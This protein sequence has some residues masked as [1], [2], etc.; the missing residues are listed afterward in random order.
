MKKK[1]GTKVVFLKTTQVSPCSFLLLSILNL[2]CS[3]GDRVMCN[4]IKMHMLISSCTSSTSI[5]DYSE[6]NR[7]YDLINKM[8][9]V[10]S[11]QYH[12]SSQRCK[13]I[14]PH[15]DN[16]GETRVLF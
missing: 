1:I 5:F 12:S 2:I 11:V 9:V 8:K 15:R 13:H 7:T 10:I 4:T 14:E 16:Y 6:I 3:E